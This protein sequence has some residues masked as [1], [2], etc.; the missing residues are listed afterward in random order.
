[1]HLSLARTS[2]T[3]RSWNDRRLCD[4]CRKARHKDETLRVKRMHKE[5][6]ICLFCVEHRK[7]SKSDF[8]AP[9]TVIE[10]ERKGR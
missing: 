4:F 1:M 5:V 6:W 8:Y 2:M 3:R 7:M 10:Y 9:S